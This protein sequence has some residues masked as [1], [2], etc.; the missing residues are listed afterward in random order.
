MLPYT[1]QVVIPAGGIFYPLD[2]ANLNHVFGDESVRVWRLNVAWWEPCDDD[3]VHIPNAQSLIILKHPQATHCPK[4]AQQL[5]TLE[6]TTHRTKGQRDAA[7]KV[8]KAAWR[9]AIAR[10]RDEGQVWVLLYCE[11]RER[12]VGVSAADQGCVGQ[13]PGRPLATPP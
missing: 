6:V 9:E 11:V 8:A 3:G 1:K 2:H 12:M 5:Y 13:F 10:S 4:F 7:A